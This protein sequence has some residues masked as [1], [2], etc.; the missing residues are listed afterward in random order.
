MHPC[1]GPPPTSRTILP[2]KGRVRLAR[3][4][5]SQFVA[6]GPVRGVFDAQLKA[7]P[8]FATGGWLWRV[9]RRVDGSR[10]TS[11]TTMHADTCAHDA[12][13]Q[14]SHIRAMGPV[15]GVVSETATHRIR[16][17]DGGDVRR[18]RGDLCRSAG[19]RLT[20][21]RVS[22]EIPSSARCFRAGSKADPRLASG[23]SWRSFFV[24]L[25][26]ALRSSRARTWAG[27]HQIPLNVMLTLA[28][29]R[30]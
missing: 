13:F 12:A 27:G 18:P 16:H 23:G 29:R 20:A 28:C 11:V 21:R 24:R 4:C 19:R 9:T 8:P 5:S 6:F 17:V 22:P 14:D 25:G 10:P 2:R 3:S 15:H 1:V 26:R 30:T 7:K